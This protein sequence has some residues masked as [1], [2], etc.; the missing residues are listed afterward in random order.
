VEI[1]LFQEKLSPFNLDINFYTF[2]VNSTGVTS[3]LF[4]EKNSV[5]RIAYAKIFAANILPLE[6]TKVVYLDTDVLILKDL[7][8]LF[9]ISFSQSIAACADSNEGQSDGSREVFNSGVMVLNLSAI[10]NKWNLDEV[11]LAFE[12][13]LVSRWMDMTILRKLFLDDWFELPTSF[14]FIINGRSQKYYAEEDISIVHFAGYPK[15]WTNEVD[16]VFDIYWRW[17]NFQALEEVLASSPSKN[18]SFLGEE[19][20]YDVLNRL[21]HS[22]QSGEIVSLR[23]VSK[24]ELEATR[25]ELEATR[26]ELEATRSELEATRSELEGIKSSNSWQILGIYRHIKK[27]SLKIFPRHKV[28]E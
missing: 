17:L 4:L 28:V 26:S 7:S 3:E 15:P 22:L 8:R 1:D 20:L 16:S 12:E 14:N 19:F 13:N 25:S 6:I 2:D 18:G 11:K 23:H 5:A 27:L 24:P 21:Y 9:E 10:R